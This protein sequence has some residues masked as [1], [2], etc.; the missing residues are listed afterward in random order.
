MTKAAQQNALMLASLLGVDEAKAS[1]RLARAVLITA[2]PG[3]KAEWAFEIGELLGRTV[4]VRFA[5]A[6]APHPEVELVIADA[7][8]RTGALHLYADLGFTNAVAALHPIAGLSGRP[9]PLHAAAAACAVT[10][11]VVHTVVGS[12]SLPQVRLPMRLDYSQLGIPPGSLDRPLDIGSGAMAGA[13]AIA[14]AFLRAA[15]HVDLRGELTVIDPKTVQAGI[16]NRCLYLREEDIGSDKATA[17]VTRAQPDFSELRLRAHVGD[18]KSYV[19]PLPRPPETT[20]VTVDSRHVR[21]HIQGEVPRRIVDASTTDARGVVIHSNVLPTDNACLA[22]IYRHVPEEHARE[23]SIA[24]GLGVDLADV[25]TGLITA[26]IAQRIVR[27]HPAIVAEDI[28]GIAFDSLFRQ[29]CS[30]QALAL[31]EGRQVL[32]PFAFVSAWAGILQVVEMLRSFA[33]MKETNYWQVD[34]W[35]TPVA[36]ARTLR[37]RHPECQFCSK[38]EYRPIIHSLW[39]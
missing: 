4:N 29:L 34:P 3:E 8:P 22:C 39:G 23:R 24:E 32:A 36:R 9:H 37:P 30:E 18:F 1:E 26:E 33:G 17:L 14:H 27:T 20:F 28:V 2:P 21:R 15:R 38:P 25:R 12:E 19:R 16:L 6:E 7:T 10:A 13:G 31:P 11:A 5:Q 35:N